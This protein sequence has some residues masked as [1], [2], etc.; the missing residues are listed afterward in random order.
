MC[1]KHIYFYMF[2]HTYIYMLHYNFEH[3]LFS[4]IF[5]F[6]ISD[7]SN[8]NFIQNVRKITCQR[9]KIK[10]Y[11]DCKMNTPLFNIRYE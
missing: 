7:K 6:V 10:Q 8:V 3:T 4:R 2:V 9:S 11:L 5:S 1:T